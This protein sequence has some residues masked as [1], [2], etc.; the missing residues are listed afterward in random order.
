MSAICSVAIAWDGMGT[1][2]DPYR[3]NN[4]NDMIAISI[5]AEAGNMYEGIYFKIDPD[6]TLDFAH[7]ELDETGSNFTPIKHFWGVFDGN[8]RSIKNLVINSKS[9]YVGLFATLNNPSAVVKNVL[10]DSSCR[11]KGQHYVGSI[12]GQLWGATVIDCTNKGTVTGGGNSI[13]DQSYVGGIVG[14]Y[15]EGTLSGCKNHGSVSDGGSY[16]GGIVGNL[17][18]L[19]TTISDCTN[20][21]TVTGVGYVGGIVG[22][23]EGKITRCTNNGTIKGSKEDYTGGI[24]ATCGMGISYCTNSGYVEGPLYVGGIAGVAFDIGTISHCTNSGEIRDTEE[25]NNNAIGGIIGDRRRCSV[26]YCENTGT[27]KCKYDAGGICGRNTGDMGVLNNNVNSGNVY[28]TY[29]HAGAIIGFS[30]MVI[31]TLSKNYYYRRSIVKIGDKTYS[32]NVPRGANGSIKKDPEDCS[33][34][35]AIDAYV[36]KKAGIAKNKY[37]DFYW[38]SYYASDEGL[39]ADDGMFLFVAQYDEPFHSRIVLKRVAAGKVPAGQGV[40]V[41]SSSVESVLAYTDED[42][43]GDYSSNVLKGVDEATETSAIDG[44]IYV[45]GNVDGVMCFKK[46][47]GTLNAHQTYIVSDCGLEVLPIS[48]GNG[49]NITFADASVKALCVANWDTNSNGELSEDEAAAVTSLGE[50]FVS[51]AEIT[52]FNELQFFTGLTEIGNSAFYGCSS[53]ASITLPTTLQALGLGVFSGCSAL[54]TINIPA[55]V[56]EIGYACFTDCAALTNITVD[57]DNANFK[58]V[59]GVL[60]TKD[61]KTLVA[62]PDGKAGTSYEIPDGTNIIN[63]YS[64]CNSKLTELVIPASVYTMGSYAFNENATLTTITSYMTDGIDGGMRDDVFSE[65]VFE[66]A[67]LFVPYGAK[68]TY[69]ATDGWKKFKHIVEMAD[70]R[71]ITVTAKS[72]T[73]KYGDTIPTFEFNSEGGSLSGTP[74]VTCEATTTS[75]VGEYDIVVDKGCV[76][77]PNVTYVNGTLTITKAPLTIT[78]KDYTIKQGETLPTFEVTYEGFKNSETEAVLTTKPTISTS[79]TSASEP[80]TYDI[81]VS[82][83]EA[84]NYEISYVKGTLTIT[85]ADAVTVTAKS[86]SREYGEA[87]PTFEYTS[88]GALLTGTPEI[89]CEATA[90]SPVGIYPIVIKKGS[91]TNYNDTYVNGTLTITKAPLTVK[92]ENATREQYLEN[93]EFVITYTGWKVGDDESVLTKKPTAATEAT[94]DSPVGTYAIVVSGGEAENYELQYQNGILTVTESTGIATVSV[95]HPADVYTLQGHKVR[96][97]ATTLEGLAKGVYIV[98]GRKIVIK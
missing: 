11:I 93:P 33:I 52:S 55:Q 64:F 39:E 62:Y 31:G 91:V 84:Q 66:N 97:N 45:L 32:R 18:K 30:S 1:E 43:S 81:T 63:D 65:T 38:A 68:A 95:T 41:S 47:E 46:F 23:N 17:G 88:E 2:N 56:T 40:I 42:V 70:K 36:L 83:A 74:T 25:T 9:D 35:G 67:T 82:G 59:D 22:W 29:G 98:N 60:Y 78:A 8:N 28:S 94:K 4:E 71:A 20:T 79:A 57:A 73:I 86:Y 87:N 19:Q 26:Q 90:S 6:V 5:G 21:G 15:E 96:T 44:T 61:G 10:L 24:S 75:S 69:K 77:N 48:E 76:S 50:V 85:A 51:N 72:Y 13:Y 34:E 80:G 3:I 7:I 54:P 92:V 14:Q 16:V 53:L 49:T 37:G 12:V 89:T 27:I 58:S